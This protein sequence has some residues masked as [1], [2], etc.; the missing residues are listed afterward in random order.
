M[1]EARQRYQIE[2]KSAKLAEKRTANTVLLLQY[3]RAN[4][5]DTLDAREDYLDAKNAETEALVD[6]AVATLE[7]FRDT[8]IMKIKPDGMWEKS[9]PLALE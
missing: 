6:Y 9:A 1:T 5:R 3:G 4:T 2:Q 7:F 8:E